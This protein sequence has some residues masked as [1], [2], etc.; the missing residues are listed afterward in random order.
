[1]CTVS[2]WDVSALLE[3]YADREYPPCVGVGGNG[4]GG[5][6]G[7]GAVEAGWGC[8]GGGSEWGGE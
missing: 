3:Q 6:V 5:W 7:V 1:M 8:G 4:N 2:D